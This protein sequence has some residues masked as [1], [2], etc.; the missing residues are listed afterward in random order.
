MFRLAFFSDPHLGPVPRPALADLFGKRLTGYVN[1]LRKRRNAHDMA[2][3]DR[4]LADLVDQRPDHI[5]CGGDLVNIALASEFP[6]A[7][8]FLRRLGDPARVS[9]VPGNHD[10]YVAAA[11]REIERHWS[12]WMTSDSGRF[13]GFPFVRMAGPVALIGLNS[14]VPTFPFLATGALGAK[15]RTDFARVMRFLWGQ[16][17]ARVVLIHHPPHRGGARFG[18]GLVDAERFEDIIAETGAEL[19]LHGHNHAASVAFLRGPGAPV[20]VVGVPSASAVSGS[21]THRAGYHLFD[22]DMTDK[23]V[24]ITG[25]TR[26][27]QPDG[28][29]GDL[30]VIDLRAAVSPSPSQ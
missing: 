25:R 8:V 17:L 15:Q 6:S 9:L 22:F 11:L 23:G 7:A 20:P 21:P 26:G 12:S 5:A 2:V 1:W 10:A 30:G 13:E 14:G 18:R 16:G 28:T 4:I 24:A 3:L 29:I 27:L 19:I